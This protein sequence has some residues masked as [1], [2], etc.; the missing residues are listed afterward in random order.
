[1]KSGMQSSVRFDGAEKESSCH[2][3]LLER[4]VS[5]EAGLAKRYGKQYPVFELTV[6][7]RGLIYLRLLSIQQY[8]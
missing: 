3:D 1:M 2:G 5:V 4:S 6:L 7:G 8:P